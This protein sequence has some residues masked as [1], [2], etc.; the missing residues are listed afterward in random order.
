M[1][2]WVKG[3]TGLGSD[4]YSMKFPV[5]VVDCPPFESIVM[6]MFLGKYYASRLQ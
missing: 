1:V 2:S 5:I 6:N 4:L 3:S